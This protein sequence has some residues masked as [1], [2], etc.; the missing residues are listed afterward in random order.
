ME[1]W[2]LCFCGMSAEND[3]VD[4]YQL[5][6]YQARSPRQATDCIERALDSEGNEEFPVK[7]SLSIAEQGFERFL[8]F[9]PTREISESICSLFGCLLHRKWGSESLVDMI[10]LDH[11]GID[12]MTRVTRFLLGRR[13]Y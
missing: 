6:N 11:I 1:T 9:S 13:I 2:F 3:V 4:G 5:E 10:I 7:T 8:L 12:Q